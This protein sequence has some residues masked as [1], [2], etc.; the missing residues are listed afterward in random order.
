[1]YPS[2]IRINL[3][4]KKK[5]SEDGEWIVARTVLPFVRAR[6]F[7][8]WQM[9]RALKLSRPEVGSSKRIIEGSDTNS[10][11]IEARLRSPPERTLRRVEPIK[12]LA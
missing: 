9:L 3:S 5:A 11:P 8:S 4:K 10:T 12:L 1:M 2:A 7:K 6:L